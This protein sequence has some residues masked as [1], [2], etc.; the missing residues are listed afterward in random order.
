MA[1]A[2]V[3]LDFLTPRDAH[4]AD[5]VA[6]RGPGRQVVEQ[7]ADETQADRLAES[8][9]QLLAPGEKVPAEEGQHGRRRGQ[10]DANT[11]EGEVNFAADEIGVL[12]A[13]EIDQ[14]GEDA[15]CDQPPE[16]SPG[17]LEQ[18]HSERG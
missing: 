6:A 13:V 17:L 10:H 15:Q 7:V 18:V 1:A 9:H 4:G 2:T 14:V 5:D 8:Q 3:R 11:K 12:V 16:P